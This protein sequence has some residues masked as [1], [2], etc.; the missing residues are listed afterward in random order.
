MFVGEWSTCCEP[1]SCLPA[2]RSN[3]NGDDLIHI[4]RLGELSASAGSSRNPQWT[5]WHSDRP[6][7]LRTG[8]SAN[9]GISA[10]LQPSCSAFGAGQSDTHPPPTHR[11][12]GISPGHSPHSKMLAES[13]T[14]RDV[15]YLPQNRSSGRAGASRRSTERQ[16]FVS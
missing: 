7:Q 4:A 5:W 3:R 11:R 13:R 1:F 8:G 10:L 12:L 14:P 6:E 16:L 2:G 9:V 15:T